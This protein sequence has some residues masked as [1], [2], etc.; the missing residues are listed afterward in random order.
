MYVEEGVVNFPEQCPWTCNQEICVRSGFKRTPEHCSNYH[1]LKH[2]YLK[3][4][5]NFTLWPWPSHFTSIA[6]SFETE[7]DIKLNKKTSGFEVARLSATGIKLT[8][9]GSQVGHL[10]YQTDHA[11]PRTEVIL[12][13]SKKM[14]LKPSSLSINTYICSV[15]IAPF[16]FVAFCLGCHLL[17]LSGFLTCIAL[18]ASS[19]SNS[20]STSS[21]RDKN[22]SLKLRLSLGCQGHTLYGQHNLLHVSS[23]QHRYLLLNNS[24]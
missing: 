19:R 16:E 4:G 6:S 23:V 20:V 21:K 22:Y 11:A 24:V 8:M 3:D 14:A 17:L 12:W 5:F 13:K 7:W 15:L 10:N 9:F 18:A 2:F 1:R